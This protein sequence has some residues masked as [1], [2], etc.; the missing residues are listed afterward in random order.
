MMPKH[1]AV[2]ALAIFVGP[3]TTGV[4]FAHSHLVLVPDETDHGQMNANPIILTLG[5]SNEP[6][7]AAKPGVHDGKHSFELSIVDA[8][9]TL[10]LSGAN[11][12]L[13][14]Y[15]FRDFRTFERASSVEGATEVDKGVPL[16][17][18][19]G[20]PG[21]YSVG[22]VVAE[23]IYG[24]RVYGMID[25]FGVAQVPVDSTMFCSTPE[26][27]SSKFNSPGWEGSYG[28]INDMDGSLFPEENSAVNNV[29]LDKR[30]NDAV[31]QAGMPSNADALNS[32]STL[33]QPSNTLQIMAT[34]IS[35]VAIAGF[36]GLRS[37]G[38]RKKK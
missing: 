7:F 28:C 13:D 31:Q 35:G 22:Q 19:F 14:R 6:A 29:N 27:N 10:P 16:R 33:G 15:Y 9:T 38:R 26:G 11:L 20:E 30:E 25:Y 17:G 8:A 4:A 5:H 1:L 36:F 24:Y 2:L 34:A 12:T 37:L 21:T 23:G 32:V 18:V 3:S